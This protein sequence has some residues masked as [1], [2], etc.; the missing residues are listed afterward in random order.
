MRRDLSGGVCGLLALRNSGVCL[1]RVDRMGTDPKMSPKGCFRDRTA[2]NLARVEGR[3][4]SFL[5]ILGLKNEWKKERLVAR[6]GCGR[7]MDEDEEAEVERHNQHGSPGAWQS[8]SNP[9]EAAKI[10]AF[11]AKLSSVRCHI[12][13]TSF[14]TG[15]GYPK[16]RIW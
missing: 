1:V 15:V 8:Q 3:K 2:L 11:L 14:N 16:T 12:T 7:I 6:Q 10:S 5:N 9:D 13:T 4:L